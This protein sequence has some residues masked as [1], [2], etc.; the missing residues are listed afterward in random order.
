MIFKNLPM[1]LRYEIISFLESKCIGCNK[2]LLTDK[3]Y[4]ESDKYT[5]CSSN[6]ISHYFSFVLNHS[7]GL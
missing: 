6:C 3:K 5:F 2:R 1:E 7:I 4:F